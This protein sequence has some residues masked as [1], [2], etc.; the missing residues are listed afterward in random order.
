MSYKLHLFYPQDYPPDWWLNF[1]RKNRQTFNAAL[2]AHNATFICRKEDGELGPRY[3]EFETQADATM[4][5]LK[6]ME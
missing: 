6:V 5:L 4:F 1:T 2:A 3:L